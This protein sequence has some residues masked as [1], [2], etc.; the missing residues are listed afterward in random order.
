MVRETSLSS[1]MQL[2]IL[3]PAM[4]APEIRTKAEKKLPVTAMDLPPRQTAVT[5]GEDVYFV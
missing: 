4:A 2:G 5:G 1:R 3:T